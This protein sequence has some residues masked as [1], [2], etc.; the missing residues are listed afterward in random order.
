[1][2]R[3]PIELFWT[4]KNNLI[5]FRHFRHLI[6]VMRRHDMTKKLTKTKTK[7]FGEHLL[8]AILET[9]DLSDI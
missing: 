3:S 9:C 7:T 1:M 6:R 5:D 4:A 8:R 2:T